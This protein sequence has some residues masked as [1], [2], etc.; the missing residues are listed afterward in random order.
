MELGALS[1]MITLISTMPKYSASSWGSLTP[2][3]QKKAHSSDREMI[4]SGLITLAVLVLKAHHFTV[5]IVDLEF[6]TASTMKMLVFS[7]HVS[8][9]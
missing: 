7:A 5:L 1:V 2:L 8:H 3:Q 6:R 4:L 9:A